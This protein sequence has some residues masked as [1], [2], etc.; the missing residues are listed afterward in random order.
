MKP[1]PIRMSH[2]AR[3]RLQSRGT[4]EY[5]VAQAVNRGVREPAKQGRFLCRHNFQYNGIWRGNHY[6]I[7]QVA[8]VIIESANEIVVVTVYTFFF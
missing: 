2:H 1:K 7:K 5:E 8:P 4:D 6:R 3:S